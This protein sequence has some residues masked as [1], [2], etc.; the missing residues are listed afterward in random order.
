M[1]N[2]GKPGKKRFMLCHEV[3]YG[4]MKTILIPKNKNPHPFDLL[5]IWFKQNWKG[6]KGGENK[7]SSLKGPQR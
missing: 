1:S 6:G 2:G 7:A 3:I 5:Q 4:I